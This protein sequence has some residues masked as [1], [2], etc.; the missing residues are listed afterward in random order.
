[1]PDP[2]TEMESLEK[3]TVYAAMQL[4]GIDRETTD[5]Y[6]FLLREGASPIESVPISP[7]RK[8]RALQILAAKGLVTASRGGLYTAKD[9]ELVLRATVDEYQRSARLV[10]KAISELELSGRSSKT[11]SLNT[12]EEFYTW[13]TKLVQRSIKGVYGLTVR[14]KLLWLMRDVI[15]E[16]IEAQNIE[17][18]VLGDVHNEETYQ[19]AIDLEAVGAEVRHSPAVGEMLRFMLF[20]TTSVLFGFRNPIDPTLHLGAWIRSEAF[21]EPLK[22]QFDAVWE[23]AEPSDKWKKFKFDG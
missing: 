19:R 18:K 22:L 16:R 11:R 6:L 12:S 4:L 23:K 3:E 15:K 21:V 20:D 17:C 2:E 8:M 7:H 10:E 1:M 9:A 5:A 14:F 13:E